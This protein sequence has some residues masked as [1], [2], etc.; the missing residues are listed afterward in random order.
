MDH[1]LGRANPVRRLTG[2]ALV[3]LLHV[4]I[5]YALVTGLAKDVIDVIRRPIET[6][7]IEE[8]KPKPPPPPQLAIPP[9]EFAAPPPPF[10]PPPEIK[11]AQ[12]PPPAP[13]VAVTHTP[14]PAPVAITPAPPP[15]PA[16]VAVAAPPPPTPAPAPVTASVA[17][18]NYRTAMG[19]AAFPREAL[20]HGLEHGNALIQF[21]L[22]ADGHVAHVEAV[23]ASDPVFAH[24]SEAIVATFQCRG[25]GRDVVVRVPFDYR[26]E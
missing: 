7:V 2:L 15:P 17:C 14:P 5:I 6:K 23:H 10:I 13:I 21:T 20:R 24:A 22:T 3:L 8:Q 16:P 12:P 25:Q 1:A 19:D 26:V 9:P 18:S 11:I 4:A